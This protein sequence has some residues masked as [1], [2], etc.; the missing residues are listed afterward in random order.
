MGSVS[1]AL[2]RTVWLT[3]AVVLLLGLAGGCRGAATAPPESGGGEFKLVVIY[4][5]E[6]NGI[7]IDGRRAAPEE[8]ERS[9][10]RAAE[11][12]RAD[13]RAVVINAH[14]SAKWETVHDI[15]ERA[16]RLECWR[17]SFRMKRGS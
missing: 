2:W 7:W 17:L 4:V 3:P 12:A 16:S 10:T 9:L 15:I 14:P 5:A 13:R 6:D 1:S 11:A 8:I